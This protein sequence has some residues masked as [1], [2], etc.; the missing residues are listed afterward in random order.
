MA[1]DKTCFVIMP[2][3]TPEI[4]GR[5]YC[6]DREHF[7]NVLQHLFIPAVEKIKFKA[8]SPKATGSDVI[9]GEIIKQL[10]G[11]DLVL[12]DISTLNANVFFEL[13]IRT[14]LD[15]PVAFVK[16]EN[17]AKIPFDTGIINH[18][19]YSIRPWNMTAA[20]DGL[21]QHLKA[22]HEKAC[23]KNSLW[24]YFGLHK[25]AEIKPQDSS[26][27]AK[28]DLV[29]MKL[30]KQDFQSGG[31]SE[32]AILA[33]LEKEGLTRAVSKVQQD[34]DD[35]FIVVLEKGAPGLMRK[36][37]Q[38]LLDEVFPKFNMAVV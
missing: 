7:S 30:D 35:S 27:D 10:D 25:T 22:T 23:G 31:V 20:I 19:T 38:G 33:L 9:Q 15:K 13:G 37:I 26:L 17:T 6:D 28:L 5:P 36:H 32:S 8:V 16:D 2:I 21:A 29:L 3:S 1:L 12:C 11:A 34:G 14:A 18:Y 4:S 24:K